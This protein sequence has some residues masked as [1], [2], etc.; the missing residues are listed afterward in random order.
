MQCLRSVYKKPDTKGSRAI[1]IT[2]QTFDRSPMVFRQRMHELREF[3]HG[4]GNIRPS[5]PEMLEA[6]DHL[7][8]HGGID[9]CSTIIS[10]QGSTNDKRCG[11]RFGDEH[12]MF[13]Q[14]INDILLLR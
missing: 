4:R 5:H 14:K 7:T 6:I 11:D 9:R 10:S 1:K 3:V 13:A 2:S 8:V 12:V